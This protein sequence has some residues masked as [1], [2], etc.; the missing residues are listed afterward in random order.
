ML[1]RVCSAVVNGIDGY[2]VEVEVKEGYGDT[3]IV[4][5]ATNHPQKLMGNRSNDIRKWRGLNAQFAQ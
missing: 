3:F 1:S 2:L 4:M 5:I